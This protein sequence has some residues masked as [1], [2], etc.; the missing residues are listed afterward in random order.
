MHTKF[1]SDRLNSVDVEHA[2]PPRGEVQQRAR[3]QP[4]QYEPSYIKI[5]LVV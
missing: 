5:G 4:E 3:T 2:A 1:Q